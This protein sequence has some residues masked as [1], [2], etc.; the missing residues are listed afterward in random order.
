L[1]DIHALTARGVKEVTFLGQNVNSYE[2]ESGADFAELLA[3]SRSETDLERIR[4]T[5]SHPKDFDEKVG[6]GDG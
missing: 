2:C 3:D 6:S 1:T 4:F 5:T